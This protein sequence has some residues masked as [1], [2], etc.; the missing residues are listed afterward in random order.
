M[1]QQKIAILTDSCADVPVH[2]SK[3]YDIH[4]VPLKLI[5]Q[6]GEYAD[7]VDIQPSEVYARL[8]NEIPKTTLPD[9]ATV[10]AA[11]ARIRAAGYTKVLAINLS[12]ALS[13]TYNMVRVI[14]E[15]TVGLEVASFDTC[16]GSLGTGLTVLQAAYWIE[17]GRSWSE[18]LRALPRLIHR[19]WAMFCVDTLEYLQKGGRIGKATAV[20]GT[21]LQIKPILS[22]AQDGE[23]INMAKVRGRKQAMEKLV[24]LIA[25]KIPRGVRFNLAL[26]HGNSP[27]E[28]RELRSLVQKSMP[29]YENLI[30]ADIGSTLGA[31]TGPHLLGVGAQILGDDLF[32]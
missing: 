19:T 9:G 3:K 10:E 11:F 6:D 17:E 5:F 12:G 26:A 25:Q 16:S 13:G 18:I 32:A 1:N 22:F 20:A 2:L 27:D 31:Y 21:L 7:G 28:L 29:D 8:K 4:V 24:H 30:E 15:Q 14:G 23:L